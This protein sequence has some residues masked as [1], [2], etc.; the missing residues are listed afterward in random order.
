M[1]IICP[2]NTQVDRVIKYCTGQIPGEIISLYIA[3]KVVNSDEQVRDL[4]PVE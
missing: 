2:L 3:E 1:A 4:Y